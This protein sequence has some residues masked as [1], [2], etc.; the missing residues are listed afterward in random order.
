MES[1]AWARVESGAGGLRVR[2]WG[3]KSGSEKDPSFWGPIIE[4]NLLSCEFLEATWTVRG[5]YELHRDNVVAERD[6]LGAAVC[7]WACMALA[8]GIEVRFRKE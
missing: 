2:A 1:D 6:A 7:E 8:L 5:S 4:S 3:W